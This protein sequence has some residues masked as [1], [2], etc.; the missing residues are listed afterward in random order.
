MATIFNADSSGANPIMD[1]PTIYGDPNII[2]GI[3][4]DDPAIM[5]VT[6][7]GEAGAILLETGIFYSRKTATKYF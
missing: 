2:I 7:L 1:I 6:G 5:N 4:E 3:G